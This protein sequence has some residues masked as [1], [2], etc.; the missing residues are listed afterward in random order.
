MTLQDLAALS[1][2]DG[3]PQRD[4]ARFARISSIVELQEQEQIFGQGEPATR[5]FILLEG[6]VAI[7]Y[8]PGDGDPLTVTVLG[9]GDVFGWSSALGR[10]R[11]T[12]SAYSNRQGR[13]LSIPGAKFHALCEDHPKT[14][15]LIIERLADVIAGRLRGTREAVAALL[16][17][18]YRVKS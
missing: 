3:I 13:A 12:S 6:E 7:R 5:L 17:N 1:L 10:S 8:K 16:H 11:Y 9:R 2:F 4:L 18:G 14:G 15:V